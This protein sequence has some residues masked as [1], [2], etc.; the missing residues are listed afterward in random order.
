MVAFSHRTI[1]RR[2]NNEYLSTPYVDALRQVTDVPLMSMDQKQPQQS[3]RE[4]RDYLDEI[5]SDR[6]VLKHLSMLPPGRVPIQIP[7]LLKAAEN[8]QDKDFLLYTNETRME[9]HLLLL[10]LLDRFREALA[11]LVA[12]DKPE[13]FD[14]QSFSKSVDLVHLCGFMLLRLSR[15]RA[16]KMHLE[17]IQTVLQEP[18]RPSVETSTQAREGEGGATLEKE[19]LLNPNTAAAQDF[20]GVL[21]TP[22]S[23]DALLKSYVAWLRLMVG[24]F[25]AVEILCRFIRPSYKSIDL[26][27][28]VAPPTERTQ[29]KWSDLVQNPKYFP[30]AAS[31]S[32]RFTNDDICKF[33]ETNPNVKNFAKNLESEVFSGTVHC[34][35]FLA[36]LLPAYFEKLPHDDSNYEKIKILSQMQVKFFPSL[37]FVT[38]I[39]NLFSCDIRILDG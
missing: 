14:R 12:M 23:A 6:Q 39:F 15:G 35:S 33:L 22:G 10:D 9:F 21:P 4:K 18:I 38:L 17:N 2:F 16:F 29:L 5:R 8:S 13:K 34:E 30:N 24:H 27:I 36:S 1:A 32:S 25:D 26:K 20:D 11:T 37:T 28:I 31:S 3:D 19:S 7:N